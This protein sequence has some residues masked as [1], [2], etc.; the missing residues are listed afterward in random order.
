MI[1]TLAYYIVICRYALGIMVTGEAP[2]ASPILMGAVAGATVF[3]GSLSLSIAAGKLGKKGVGALQ[4]FSGGILAYLALEVGSS[5]SEYVEG[6][7]SSSRL[8]EFAVASIVTT[9]ALFGTWTLLSFSERWKGIDSLLRILMAPSIPNGPGG[10]TAGRILYSTGKT[11][12]IIAIGLGL[13]NIGEGFAIATALLQGMIASAV[14]FTI[15]FAIHNFTEGFAITGPLVTGSKRT[16]LPVRFLL[17]ASLLAALPTLLGVL[18]YYIAP[19]SD[20]VLALLGTIA[21]ASLVYSLIRVNLSAL[22]RLGGPSSL[23]FWFSLG[24]G[25]A[26]TYTIEALV[27]L[28]L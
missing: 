5:V 8:G 27:L 9:L 23:A 12:L 19:P 1:F 11:S 26:V 16:G 13:H 6:L 18:V 14:L 2:F 7:A 24:A 4:A 28:T 3:L 15:G 20:M 25:V 21:E 10:V 17:V 22:G